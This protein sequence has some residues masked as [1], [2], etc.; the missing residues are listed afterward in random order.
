MRRGVL[1][2]LIC[3]VPVV[4]MA[5]CAGGGTSG[6]STTHSRT[7]F[8]LLGVSSPEEVG[9]SVSLATE[10]GSVGIVPVGEAGRVD[11][12]TKS[13]DV[14]L[15][16]QTASSEHTIV[17]DNLEAQGSIVLL[18]GEIAAETT[19]FAG[20]SFELALRV[21]S[22]C[23][24]FFFE[25]TSLFLKSEGL[26]EACVFEVLVKK[27]G[28]PL[29]GA[30]VNLFE[31]PC[32]LP[33]AYSAGNKRGDLLTGTDGVARVSLDLAPLL[34]G[35]CYSFQALVEESGRMDLVLQIVP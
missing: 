25:N 30:V 26:P 18:N 32:E 6:T 13:G 34:E 22:N 35:T 24:E 5:A 4:V 10:S 2:L 3:I 31:G 20:E 7:L 12:E 15:S 8:A 21:E 29:S 14:T 9:S 27:Q 33:Q 1:L 23:S 17:L 19:E 16:L 11:F 28:G